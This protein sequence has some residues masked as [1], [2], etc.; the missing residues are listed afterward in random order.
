MT[1]FDSFS[2]DQ[3]NDNEGTVVLGVGQP[4]RDYYRCMDEVAP[5]FTIVAPRT[6]AIGVGGS[7]LCSGF[8]WLSHEFGCSSDPANLL[9]VEAVLLDGTVTWLK[10]KHDDLL[11]ALR[12]TEGGFGV[13]TRFKFRARRYEPQGKIWAG[14]VLVPRERVAEVAKGL[15]GMSERDERG[16]VDPKVRPRQLRKEGA[17]LMWFRSRYSST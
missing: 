11:W 10:G 2:F 14:A 16:K 7:T 17:V 4:W 12:G 15:T 8:S 5:E 1:A 6:P 9:D 13:C 3:E